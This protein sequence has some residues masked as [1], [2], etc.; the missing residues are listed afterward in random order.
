L[1]AT[2]RSVVHMSQRS[3]TCATAARRRRCK[4]YHHS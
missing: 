1:R 3:G 2:L 4:R